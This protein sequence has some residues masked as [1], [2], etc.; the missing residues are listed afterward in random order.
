M[1]PPS[2]EPETWQRTLEPPF[3][4]DYAQ[5][6]SKLRAFTVSGMRALDD[7]ERRLCVAALAQQVGHAYED[8]AAVLGGLALWHDPTAAVASAKWRRQTPL[9]N[10]PLYTFL[11]KYPS[12]LSITSVCALAPT[13]S[14][15]FEFFSL[16]ELAAT[17]LPGLPTQASRFALDGLAAHV[18]G[19]VIPNAGE[20]RLPFLKA[21]HGAPISS[22]L[23]L[24]GGTNA[25]PGLLLE[26]ESAGDPKGLAIPLALENVLRTEIERAGA[27]SRLLVVLYL[28]AAYPA[29]SDEIG[30]TQA[31]LIDILDA[32]VVDAM[33]RGPTNAAYLDFATAFPSNSD[34]AR[35]DG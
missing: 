4:L 30:R 1:N 32:E 22:D 15:F 31:P 18:L 19:A 16:A 8:L 13:P 25:S 35:Q 24:F 33:R 11:A 34:L 3:L 28:Y 21:K 7:D 20:L 5:F 9:M 2:E 12:G 29:F 26:G 6:G 10:A 27:M 14:E 23:S 17:Q